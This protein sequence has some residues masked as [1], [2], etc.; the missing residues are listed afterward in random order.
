MS[1]TSILA[2]IP[3]TDS[4]QNTQSYGRLHCLPVV[5]RVF[6]R[7]SVYSCRI[8]KPLITAYNRV[9]ILNCYNREMQKIKIF[10]PL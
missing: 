3:E 8:D 4:C 1:P 5:L 9:I 2:G 7:G 6:G 10:R